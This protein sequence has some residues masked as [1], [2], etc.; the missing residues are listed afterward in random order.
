MKSAKK[1]SLTVKKL[2]AK[3]AYY[4]Q[5]RTYKTVDGKKLYS[6]WSKMKKVKT[7]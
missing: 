2:K 1:A 4:V 3:R 6:S 5:I 7:K